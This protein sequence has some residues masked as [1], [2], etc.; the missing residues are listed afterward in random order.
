MS[1]ATHAAAGQPIDDTYQDAQISAIHVHWCDAES[2]YI[3]RSD[4]HPG[5][6]NTDRWSSLAAMNGL[7]DI[8]RERIE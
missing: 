8:I 2:G 4:Q 7:L 5:I 3:A 6:T 1:T